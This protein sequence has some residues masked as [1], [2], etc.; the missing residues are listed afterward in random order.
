MIASDEPSGSPGP[1]RVARLL[2]IGCAA[3]VLSSFDTPVANA[4]YI[5]INNGLAPPN[6]DNVIDAPPMPSTD[7]FLVRNTDCPPPATAAYGPCPSP[8]TPTQV[9]VL[10][11]AIFGG[12]SINPDN[13]FTENAARDSSVIS[14]SG[15]NLGG[16]SAR[17][18]ARI[19]VNGG[20]INF[21]KALDSSIVLLVD[22]QIPLYAEAWHDASLRI[23]G[24]NVGSP[25]FG[26]VTTTSTVPVVISGGSFEFLQES[27]LARV[28]P[29]YILEGTNFAID[30]A[31]AEYGD[32]F[33]T[34]GTITGTWASGENFSVPINATFF[35][36]A[37]PAVAVPALPLLPALTLAVMLFA[38][39]ASKT[40]RRRVA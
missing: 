36:L 22:G 5:L 6:P 25:G 29:S 20:T 30:G 15:G 38:I 33:D 11:G 7:L 2:S 19:T 31:P 40:R 18:N 13:N 4:Q 9:E 3:L 27:G 10:A 37:P 17:E 34:S 23:R 21:L 14:M 32:Y 28:A 8:G 12:G 35:R 24:G 16:L 1:F 39:G 26:G